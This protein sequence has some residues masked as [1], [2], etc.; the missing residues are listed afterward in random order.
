MSG[1]ALVGV[2]LATGKMLFRYEHITRYDVN[3]LKPVCI[4]DSV[5]ISSGYGSGSEMIKLTADGDTLKAQQV[6]SSKDMDNHHNGVVVTGGFIYGCDSR[7]NWICYDWESG[8][9]MY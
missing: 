1:K 2:D 6:W 3:A 4:N 7:R 8:K 5:F 9:T